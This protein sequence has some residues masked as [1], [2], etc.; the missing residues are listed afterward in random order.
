[1]I[2]LAYLSSATDILDPGE[3][4]SLLAKA[5]RNN[6]DRQVTGML[7][8]YDG[9]FLQ[10]LEG[11]AADVEETFAAIQA[12][13]RHAGIIEVYRKPIS[14]RIFADWTMALVR[15]DEAGPEQRAFCRSLREVELTA[16]AEHLRA[17]APFLDS[18]RAWVR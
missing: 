16:P 9:S 13:P 11:E 10:F 6:A 12:D 5:R 14:H 17:I 7:C 1:M 4:Q 3:L 2:C 18:F 15:V 8:Y